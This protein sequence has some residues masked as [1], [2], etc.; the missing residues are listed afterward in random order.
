MIRALADDGKTILVSS[1]ILTEL[2]EMCDRVG[3]I[4]RGE[5]LAVGTVAEIRRGQVT[6]CEI[7]A[8]ILENMPAVAAWLEGHG[9]IEN[10]RVDGQL[11]RFS[12]VG[13][14]G[15]QAKLLREMIL[16]EFAV[17]EFGIEQRSLE[18]V[19]MHVTR[20]VVQ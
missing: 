18:D 1:H 14:T 15:E 13:E 12:H 4:E 17:A 9:D 7:K 16:A 10:I 19:F 20:G 3:I 6:H 11:I 5:L 8:R 2:A